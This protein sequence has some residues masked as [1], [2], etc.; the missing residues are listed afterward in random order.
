MDR[1]L[2]LYVLRWQSLCPLK[3]DPW[4][5]AECVDALKAVEFSVHIINEET[6]TYRDLVLK[7]WTQYMATLN[8]A[9]LSK[10][11]AK[12]LAVEVE[13]WH[14]LAHVMEK[15]ELTYMRMHVSRKSMR[16]PSDP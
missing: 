11:F 6:P 16:L 8:K 10:D 12:L 2:L 3:P 1:A 14:Q 9:E 13:R 7:G 15:G 5:K 4:T